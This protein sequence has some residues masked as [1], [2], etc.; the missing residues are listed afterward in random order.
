VAII[1]EMEK[2][3]PQASAIVAH[4]M[5]NDAYS[6]WLGIEVLACAPG[7]V[8]LRMTVSKEMTNGFGIAHGGIC[9]SLSDSALAFAANAHG[10]MAMSIDTS[11]R[12]FA[13][14]KQGD[15]LTARTEEL[16]L[17]HRTA[18]YVVRITNQQGAVV[19]H[20]VGSVYRKSE[21]WK[22]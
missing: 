20:F 4:M 18:N 6:Q 1:G 15:L 7:D 14:V 16:Q 21:A 10:R 17:S 2:E 5:R 13:A 8:Q 3:T 22:L 11:I 9:Y 19:S 12:H